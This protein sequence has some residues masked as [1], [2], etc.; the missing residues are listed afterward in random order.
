MKKY[1]RIVPIL[2]AVLAFG[3]FST[4][5]TFTGGTFANQTNEAFE[6][7][8]EQVWAVSVSADPGHEGVLSQSFEAA[9]RVNEETGEFEDYFSIEQRAYTSSGETRRNIDI[10]SPVSGAYVMDD[11]TVT[12]MADIWETFSMDNRVNVVTAVLDWLDLF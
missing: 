10:S 7:V 12:G 1:N 2:F 9:F 5:F 6:P 3:L 4:A 8:S 11:M